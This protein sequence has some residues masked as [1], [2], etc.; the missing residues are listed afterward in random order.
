[1][2][3]LQ[4]LFRLC[5]SEP[6]HWLSDEPVPDVSVHWVVLDAENI[7][8]GDILLLP[9]GKLTPKLLRQIKKREGAAVILLGEA[10]PSESVTPYDFPVLQVTSEQ[11]IREVYRA[12]VT[13]LINQRAY[14]ME[15]GV[16]I[17]AQLAQLEAE[18][19]GIEGYGVRDGLSRVLRYGR[20][21]GLGR[22]RAPRQFRDAGK[23]LKSVVS[24]EPYTRYDVRGT[25]VGLW[26]QGEGRTSRS[27][28]D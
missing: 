12:M 24:D 27:R 3:T 10:P 4:E 14:L 26:R 8:K 13:I 5:F 18:G 15:R 17:H 23:R 7:E 2:F 20:D 16:R 1:M 6:L 22:S 19:A 28:A 11:E 21:T 9:E 25:P